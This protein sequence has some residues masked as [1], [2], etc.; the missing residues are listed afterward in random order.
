M[1]VLDDSEVEPGQGEDSGDSPPRK[2]EI[3]G[4]RRALAA[5][6]NEKR[7]LKSKLDELSASVDELKKKPSKE[8]THAELQSFVDDGRMS[9]AEADRIREQQMERKLE[10]RVSERLESKT[11]A[12]ELEGR[13]NAE[14]Q[15]YLEVHP[16]IATE[17]SK[18]RNL[19]AEEYQRQLSLGKPDNLQTEI[20]ALS[21]VFGPSSR[22]Q[23]AREK[24]AETHQDV[25]SDSGGK[26]SSKGAP[27]LPAHVKEHYEKLI[28]MRHYSGWDDP[29]LKKEVENYGSR[30]A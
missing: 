4:L 12:K 13:L 1:S 23:K 16:E 15:R 14:L 10:E 5:E 2:E 22:L 7:T 6:R 27:K 26:P 24:E 17:G 28:K 8:Y 11:S 25:G 30:W 18:E 9:Q 20:D 29:V 3:E 21:V 19:V